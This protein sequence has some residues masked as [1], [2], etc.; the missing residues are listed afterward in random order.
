MADGRD[1]R[2]KRGGPDADAVLSRGGRKL[3]AALEKFPL[4]DAVR[5]AAAVDVG[6]STGGF[7]AALLRHGARAVTAVDVG[8][9]QLHTALRGDAR[10]TSLE[11]ADWKTLS[12]TQAAGPFD[13][14]T[15]DVSFVAARS[16]LR[17]LAFRLRDGAQGIVLVKPQFELP[18]KQVRE[19]K[20]D[21]PNL[22]RAAMERFGDK[23]RAL[24]F[25]ILGA[26]DSPVAGGSGTVE[27]LAWLRFRG[28]PDSMPRPGERRE[29]APAARR[30]ASR[31]DQANARWPWF[32]ISGPGLEGVTADEVGALPGVADV[33]RVDG[34]VEFSAPP[35]VAMRANLWLRTATRVV[36]R[37]GAAPAREFN[38]LRRAL[39]GLP[40]ERFVGADTAVKIS[41]TTSRCRLFHT[42]ALAE[43]TALA[44][45]DRVKGWRADQ[46]PATGGEP[47]IILL[48]GVEDTFTVSVDSSGERLHR[49]GWRLETAA[50]PL[51]ETLGAGLLALCGWDSRTAFC[52]PMCGAGTMVIEACA[53]ALN[54]A[55]GLQ[56]DFAFQRW[57]IFDA[58]LAAAWNDLRGE[59]QAARRS[60]PA[61]P[62]VGSDRSPQAIEAAQRNATRGG[63][64]DLVAL[65]CAELGA[66]RPPA[67]SGL[68]LL[69]PPY[70][71]RLGHP[72]AATRLYRDIGRILRAHF[73]GWRV[74]L[75]AANQ[76][77]ANASGLRATTTH[78][79]SN[80]G[81]PVTLLV[82]DL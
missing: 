11:N 45:A 54:L 8:H 27:I 78:R 13:F 61:A 63:F 75:L 58:E 34:G 79:L 42:G 41:A 81:L 19:G 37:L 72:H 70:G 53:Q 62:I 12:L 35:A 44:I 76:A 20:V 64:G 10:V 38:R 26:E 43:T 9:G 18:D 68:A 14:F 4:G 16:M 15:V 22:R 40:W 7:T 65:T 3:E 57:P 24:G 5:A 71:R 36:A 77:A 49:R 46:T 21:D 47:L 80:G 30:R 32:L 1:G 51:R 73:R 29:K 52:D 33:Q 59:A 82:V 39:A 60:Q 66:V 74:G 6:A 28:R 25:E 17:G 56:R 67:A 31:A 69:N 48:R 55:P 2:G 23:A 50:A